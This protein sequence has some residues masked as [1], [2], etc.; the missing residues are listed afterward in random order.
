MLEAA[1]GSSN[2]WSYHDVSSHPDSTIG[3][4][5]TIPK[6]SMKQAFEEVGL[7]NIEHLIKRKYEFKSVFTIIYEQGA[8]C[9]D[10]EIP[11]GIVPENTFE[12]HDVVIAV[13]KDKSVQ[14]KMRMTRSQVD[15]EINGFDN[16]DFSDT[17]TLVPLVV[18][19]TEVAAEALVSLAPVATAAVST[20]VTAEVPTL[21]VSTAEVGTSEPPTTKPKVT[22]TEADMLE[23]MRQTIIFKDY[24]V[25]MQRN[26]ARSEEILEKAK[27]IIAQQSEQIK[28]ARTEIENKSQEIVRC[29]ETITQSV[30]KISQLTEENR[31]LKENAQNVQFL[32]R[33]LAERDGA[34]A[35]YKAEL[36]ATQ[37]SLAAANAQNLAMKSTIAEQQWKLQ[38]RSRDTVQEPVSNQKQRTETVPF[39]H[40]LL[41][42]SQIIQ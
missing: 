20:A 26:S 10:I 22:V 36:L 21:S 4:L 42:A 40:Q 27:T 34:I 7:K 18:M 19:A 24:A 37:K 17:E 39:V 23:S 29:N 1:Q 15:L 31:V 16:Q 38:K 6:G 35:R 25:T 3:G 5:I 2:A 8:L 32:Q 30:L 28:S 41:K 33:T 12:T 13:H 9:G 11:K 14:K